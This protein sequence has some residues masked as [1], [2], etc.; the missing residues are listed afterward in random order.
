MAEKARCEPCDR[1]FK[2]SEGL[3]Q[4]IAAKHPE[5]VPKEKKSLPVK[6]IKNWGIF[7]VIVGLVIFGL[8]W[9]ISSGASAQALPPT[10]MEGHTERLPPSH[11]LKKP[12]RID[13]QK[14]MLEHVDGQEGGKGGVIINYDCNNFDCESG[15]IE[16]LESFALN[17]NNVYVA[18]F[19]MPVKIAITKLGRI[20]T[21]DE[22][23]AT[24]I[25]TFIT[26]RVPQRDTEEDDE[27]A[28]ENDVPEDN[29]IS[30]N[31]D[32]MPIEV[33]EISINAKRFNFSPGIITVKEG[34]RVRLLINNQD[35]THGIN[36]PDLGVSGNNVVEFTAD[37]KGE[38][39][40]YCGNYCGAGHSGMQGTIIVE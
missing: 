21:L 22:Y 14:H 32:D 26:G 11:I 40:F 37:K 27:P 13:V 10:S 19:N 33:R 24:K 35:T 12:M 25:E 9:L 4:H 36:I 2:D 3:R 30:A 15:L 5:L 7:I 34:E 8:Y 18:P 1:T 39:T 29:D 20:E 23:D 38:F 17:Y 16:N 28:D 6:K 31:E